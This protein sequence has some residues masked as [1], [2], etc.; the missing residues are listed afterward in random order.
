[1]FRNVGEKMEA[2][3]TARTPKFER[4]VSQD[5]IDPN[6]S[7]MFSVF[8]RL[9]ELVALFPNAI[10]EF[11]DGIE[12]CCGVCRKNAVVIPKRKANQLHLH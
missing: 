3:R 5:A 2:K 11:M 6:V 10:N 12:I 8:I 1:M 7:R 4:V 9:T